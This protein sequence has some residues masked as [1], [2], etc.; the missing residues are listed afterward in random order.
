[1]G[2]VL[3]VPV[4][5]VDMDRCTGHGR[6]YALAPELFSDDEEGKPLVLTNRVAGE[7]QKRALEAIAA[8]PEAAISLI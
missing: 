5:L 1:M 3:D 2:C 6:C 8:C 4:I 7:S